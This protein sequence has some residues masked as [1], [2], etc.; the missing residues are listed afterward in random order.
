VTLA[1]KSALSSKTSALPPDFDAI[2]VGVI[3]QEN[4]GFVV[5]R[6]IS[7]GDE[8]LIAAIVRKSQRIFIQYPQESRLTAPV[9]YIGLTI[10]ACGCE[11]K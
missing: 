1:I 11:I 9:L 10:G 3:H 6:E 5:F 4:V 7:S 2:A 8:L